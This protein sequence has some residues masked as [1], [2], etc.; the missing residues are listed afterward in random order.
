MA[1]AAF[2][3][4]SHRHGP[5]PAVRGD[6][7]F[8][9]QIDNSRLV[10]VAD[11]QERREFLLWLLIGTVLFAAGLA[12]AWERFALVRYG[13]AI[14]ELKGQREAL[15][16]SNRQ[17]R[18]EEASL[19]SPERIDAIARTDLGLVAPAPKQVMALEDSSPPPEGTEV[20]AAR[21]GQAA[22]SGPTSAGRPGEPGR[23][24][25]ASGQAVGSP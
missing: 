7:Y 20:A 4:R 3:R 17:L 5:R 10:R 18:L 14:E 12:Y 25:A 2:P 11:P 1:A 8:V 15:M 6:I 9:K 22:G 23:S 13:Y 21:L 16:E 19:R 24:S